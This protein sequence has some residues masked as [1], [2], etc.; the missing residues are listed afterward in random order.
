MVLPVPGL[1]AIVVV[2]RLF[3]DNHDCRQAKTQ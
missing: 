2:G 1:V 3:E